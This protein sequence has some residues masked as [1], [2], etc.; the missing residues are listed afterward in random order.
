[1]ENGFTLANFEGTREEAVRRTLV[2]VAASNLPPS[3]MQ[4]FIT[5]LQ[6]WLKR[7][8][9]KETFQIKQRLVT[10]TAKLREILGAERETIREALLELFPEEFTPELLETGDETNGRRASRKLREV[11][12]ALELSRVRNLNV[13]RALGGDDVSE[14]KPGT[15]EWSPAV[16]AAAS[17]RHGAAA[18]IWIAN[19]RTNRARKFMDPESLAQAF[20]EAYSIQYTKSHPSLK[21]SAWNELPGEEHEGWQAVAASLQ[22]LHAEAIDGSGIEEEPFVVDL[23]GAGDALGA[24]I[25]A[26][27]TIHRSNPY[28]QLEKLSDFLREAFPGQPVP[29]GDH[30]LS[31]VARATEILTAVRTYIP[32]FLKHVWETAIRPAIHALD[33]MGIEI[34]P[35][36]TIVYGAD[37]KP[38][39]PVE[40]EH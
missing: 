8:Q 6:E 14:V 31:A 36:G 19:Q 20:W 32:L 13:M 2:A 23:L 1:M 10:E 26:L 17:L 7:D 22:A 34:L 21:L 18:A 5:S 40:A 37:K 16:E 35:K 30:A 15:E 24:A 27:E 33:R 25:S 11:S 9:D 38:S 29:E 3:E 39:A 4:H 28:G 12:A